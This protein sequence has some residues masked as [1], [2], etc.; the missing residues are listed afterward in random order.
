[1]W[2]IRAWRTQAPWLILLAPLALLNAALAWLNRKLQRHDAVKIAKRV[3]VVGN[4][5]LG[6]SGKTPFAGWLAQELQQRGKKVAIISKGYGRRSSLP[7]PQRANADPAR[8]G[9]EPAMLASQLP[10][11]SVWVCDNR[12]VAIK[13]VEADYLICDDGLQ[14]YRFYPRIEIALL[15][16]TLGPVGRKR[17]PWGVLREPV[18]RL[19]ACDLVIQQGGNTLVHPACGSFELVIEGFTN[20][21]D[22][23][24][25]TL[26]QAQADWSNTELHLCCALANNQRVFDQF[27]AMGFSTTKHAFPDHHSFIAKDILYQGQVLLTAK[28][29]I[30]CATFAQSN[31]WQIDARVHMSPELAGRIM[32]LVM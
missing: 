13:T 5:S 26:A 23:S 30:K 17:F 7:H 19:D 3:I 11:L 6:G 8:F 4:I 12:L 1:M 29:A 16:A 31:C 15:D 9:D 25:K 22:G 24:C 20:L 32:R 2:L 21:V 10:Q 14:D 28:D 18:T 27:D